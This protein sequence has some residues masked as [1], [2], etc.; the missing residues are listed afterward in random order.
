[1]ARPEALRI[2]LESVRERSDITSIAVVDAR[3][4]VIAGMG[5]EQELAILGAVAEPVASGSMNETCERL[6]A[7]TDVFARAIDG[8]HY[9]AALGEKVSRMSEAS[10]AVKRILAA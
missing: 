10:L 8:R 4:L 7:G 2:L 5:T 1:M 9:L 6:T 3:G